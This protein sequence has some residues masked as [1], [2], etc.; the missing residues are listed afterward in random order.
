MLS[1][2]FVSCD[3]I[4]KCGQNI[5]LINLTNNIRESLVNKYK[6]ND[7]VVFAGFTESISTLGLTDLMV[8]PSQ[9]E[10][11]PISVLEAFAMNVPVIRTRTGGYTDVKGLCL[12]MDFDDHVGLS[13]RI[14]QVMTGGQEINDMCDKAYKFVKKTCTSDVMLKKLENIYSEAILRS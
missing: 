5:V 7:V 9:A 1:S 11:F 6:L 10:G 14:I 8:L 12:D 13:E 3:S 4:P 2:F